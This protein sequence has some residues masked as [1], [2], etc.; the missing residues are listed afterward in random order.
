MDKLLKHPGKTIPKQSGHGL[1]SMKNIWAMNSNCRLGRVF[2]E[3]FIF[4]GQL[5]NI[6]RLGRPV[7]QNAL[8]YDFTRDRKEPFVCVG[9]GENLMLFFNIDAYEFIEFYTDMTIAGARELF[10][11]LCRNL[12]KKCNSRESDTLEHIDEYCMA[13]H[14]G[15]YALTDQ[16]PID[17]TR[18]ILSPK[19]KE[20]EELKSKR[21]ILPGDNIAED[22]YWVTKSS[23]DTA[24]NFK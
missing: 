12:R 19:Q 18:L 22:V 14:E 15:S 21:T 4:L 3:W 10:Q 24:K 23:K 11:Q 13:L 8:P 1:S 6:Q 7:P 16:I 9:S 20:K 2:K 17:S 5:D